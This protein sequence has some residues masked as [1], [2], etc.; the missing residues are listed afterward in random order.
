MIKWKYTRRFLV[1]VFMI[2]GTFVPIDLVNRFTILLPLVD[3]F[4]NILKT[5]NHTLFFK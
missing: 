1:L 5:S 4:I 2:M 3:H